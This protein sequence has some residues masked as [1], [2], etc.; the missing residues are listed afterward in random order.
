MSFRSAWRTLASAVAGLNVDAVV[1]QP[2][3]RVHHSL[4]GDV[5]G[6]AGEDDPA[7]VRLPSHQCPGIEDVGHGADEDAAVVQQTAVG[8]S[9]LSRK[10]VLLSKTLSPISV[11]E[12]ADT[13]TALRRFA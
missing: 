6:E 5:T 4:A 11:F 12:E 10:I 1:R 3:E 13:A 7:N 2:T 8:E 9:R